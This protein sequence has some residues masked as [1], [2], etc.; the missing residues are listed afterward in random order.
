MADSQIERRPPLLV[1]RT[2]SQL[3]ALPLAPV[4][5][6]MRPQPLQAIAG[7]PSFV[8]GLAVVRGVPTP[9]VDAAALLGAGPES[10]APSR[11]VSLNVGGRQFALA[12]DAVLGVRHVDESTL[13]ELP[14]LLSSVEREIVSA[15]GTLDNELLMILAP[16]RLVP[17]AV[18]D[19]IDASA[20]R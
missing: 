13:A 14:S 3:C 4:I 18:W 8:L 16:V 1:V 2:G 20:T 6:T 11:I 19:A 17:E 10:T 9:V 15:V 12:V 7:I 5:E